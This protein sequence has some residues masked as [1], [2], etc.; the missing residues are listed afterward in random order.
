M[1]TVQRQRRLPSQGDL[2]Q[3]V[4]SVVRESRELIEERRAQAARREQLLRRKDKTARN[5][6]ER[7]ARHRASMVNTKLSSR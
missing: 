2:M 5:V 7:W 6:G 1:K 4:W 3:R